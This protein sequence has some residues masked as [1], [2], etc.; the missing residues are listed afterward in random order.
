MSRSRKP[1]RTPAK[2][3][4]PKSALP[5]PARGS[6]KRRGLAT[7][8]SAMGEAAREEE[9]QQAK[10]RPRK[11]KAAKPQPSTRVGKKGLVLYVKPEITLALRRLALDNNSD[12]QRMG[13][14]ALELLFAEYGKPLPGAEASKKT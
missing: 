6:R 13:H 12:V 10:S 1:K 3:K 14:R 8:S 9:A 2:A 11:A 4:T 5:A 7:A